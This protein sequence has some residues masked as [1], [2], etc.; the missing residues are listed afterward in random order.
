MSAYI[1]QF[2]ISVCISQ[3]QQ[4]VSRSL[5]S[6]RKH[7]C[8]TETIHAGI[9]YDRKHL[10]TVTIHVYFTNGNISLLWPSRCISRLK[11]SL[12]H[13]DHPCIFCDQKLNAFVLRPSRFIL[14][15]KTSLPTET[16]KVDVTSKTSLHRDHS[17][18]TDTLTWAQNS[19]TIGQTSRD[20][21]FPFYHN[22]LRRV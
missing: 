17:V 16:I 7:R 3:F 13:C 2:K 12:G 15:L 11:T 19:K 22:V 9:F 4:S 1:S 14:R 21:F 20:C 10:L 5:V 18:Q 6:K 8:C